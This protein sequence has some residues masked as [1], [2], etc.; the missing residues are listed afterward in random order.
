MEKQITRI[1]ISN[2]RL[3]VYKA[4]IYVLIAIYLNGEYKIADKSVLDNVLII[5]TGIAI[6]GEILKAF[7]RKR[8][9]K[10]I[11]LPPEG[12]NIPDWYNEKDVLGNDKS[13]S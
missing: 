10:T 6:L 2:L 13:R 3:R 12:K 11:T 5:L 1:D 4:C 8:K 9:R 7:E